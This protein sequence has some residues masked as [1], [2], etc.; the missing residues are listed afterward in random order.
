MKSYLRVVL[1][2]KCNISCSYCFNEN[3]P[4]GK[5][6]LEPEV[7]RDVLKSSGLKRFDNIILSGGEPLLNPHFEEIATISKDFASKVVLN[8]NGI[9]IKDKYGIIEPMMRDKTLDSIIISLDRLVPEEF[10]LNTETPVLFYFKIMEGLEKLSEFTS[11]S[12]LVNTVV[13]KKTFGEFLENTFH[14][15][16]SYGVRR[17][18]LIPFM[19]EQAVKRNEDY[20]VGEGEPTFKDILNH[21]KRELDNKGMDYAL[22][23]AS[24]DM[25]TL[26]FIRSKRIG[27]KVINHF[28]N[29]EPERRDAAWKTSGMMSV[30]PY[31]GLITPD[32]K[33]KQAGPN[34][35]T[36]HYSQR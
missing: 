36:S 31:G 32:V 11:E 4:V 25:K 23:G 33:Y 1:T 28:E 30:N 3:F 6:F 10:R 13:S 27:I 15:S 8:T 2:N 26:V 5:K 29:L 21:L 18:K 24:G 34:W 16:E 9:L 35:Y 17:F 7:L 19:K 20:G 14:L 12:V 22:R